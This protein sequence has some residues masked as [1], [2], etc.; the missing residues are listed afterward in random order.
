[1]CLEEALSEAMAV[2]LIK[3]VLNEISKDSTSI[4]HLAKSNFRGASL[5]AMQLGHCGQ[6]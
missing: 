5:V 6:K 4:E 1:M 2:V 3:D